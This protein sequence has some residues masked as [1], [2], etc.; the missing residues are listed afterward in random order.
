[1]V[2][3]SGVG[4]LVSWYRLT[5]THVP[6]PVMV[7]QDSVMVVYHSVRHCFND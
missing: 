7:D 3:V 1:M 2:N 5:V 4:I 6:V